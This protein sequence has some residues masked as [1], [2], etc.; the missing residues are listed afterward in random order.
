M[1]PITDL[2]LDPSIIEEI[3][4]ESLSG[5]SAFDVLVADTKL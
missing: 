3:A 2:G 5:F 1:V 4:G